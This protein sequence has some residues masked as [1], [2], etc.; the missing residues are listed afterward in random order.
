MIMNETRE[1]KDLGIG[2]VIQV[3]G[4]DEPMV[5]RSAKKIRGGLEA[6]KLEVTLVAPDGETERVALG[7]EEPVKVVGKDAEA[8]SGKG[9]GKARAK[10]KAKAKPKAEMPSAPAPERQLSETPAPQ[11][12]A[13]ASK[14]AGRRKKPEGE[15]KLSALDAAAKLLAETG[16]TMN[17]QEMIQGMAEKGY[18]T[19]PGGKTPQATLYSAILREIQT[20]GKDARFRKAERGKFARADGN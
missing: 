20:K 17:C 7:P 1:V 14:K 9:K 8:G 16:G 4:F 12:K 2:D 18:W 19:S 13:A 11:P 5:V 10:A 15:K 6:G 3:D